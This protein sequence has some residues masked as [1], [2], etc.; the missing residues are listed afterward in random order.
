ML[1][2]PHLGHRLLRVSY[3]PLNSQPTVWHV[4]GLPLR[5]LNY[6][7]IYIYYL[8]YYYIIIYIIYIYIY[9]YYF[10]FFADLM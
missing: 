1:P 7:Y 6:I 2:S 8:Y 5:L 9:Y 10:F 3:L 4:A